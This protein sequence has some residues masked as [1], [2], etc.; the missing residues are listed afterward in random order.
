MTNTTFH[1]YAPFIQQYIYRKGWTDLREVQVD[2]CNAI[3]DTDDHVIIA[4]GTASGKTEAAFFPILTLL[5]QNPSAS[6]GILYIG[7]L[8]ALIN[9]QFQRLEELL[10]DSDIPVWPWHGDVSQSVKTRIRRKKQG[11]VQITPESLESLLMRSPKDAASLFSDLRFVVVDEIHA[12]MGQDRGLQLLC[13]L[14]RLEKF[15]GCSPRRIGLSA[16]LNDYRPAI[17]FLSAGTSRGTVAVGIS[18]HT[19]KIGLC[20]DAFPVPED[21]VQAEQ[22]MMRY[23]NFIYDNCHNRKCLIFT[24]SRNDAETT[25][26]QMKVIA[27][28]RAEPDIFHVHHGSISAQLR[29]EAEHALRD[30]TLPTVAAAT[31]TLELGIDIGDLDSTIQ[32]GAP[33]SCSS[34][35]QRLGRSG[36]R[37]GKSKMMFLS[38]PEETNSLHPDALPWDLLRSLAIIQLYL[39]E[40]WVEPFTMK[41]KPFS[42]LAHQTLSTLMSQGELTPAELARRVLLLPP[43]RNRIEPE[44]YRDLLRNMIAGDYLQRMDNGG[45]IPGMKGERIAGHYTFYSVFPEE[46]TYQVIAAG[47]AIGTLTNCPQP[48]EGF[49]LA[50][51]AWR[52]ITVDDTRKEIHAV[53]SSD[54][55]IPSWSGNSG[56]IHGKIFRRI[57]RLLDETTLWPYLRPNAADLL[58]KARQT[59]ADLGLN[60]KDLLAV[61][62]HSF[63]LFPWC[64]TRQLR[65]L[66]KL[67]TIGLREKLRIIQVNNCEYYLDIRTDLSEAE[68]ISRLRNLQIADISPDLVL[69]P[70]RAPRTD[71]YDYMVPD[72]LLRKAYLHNQMDIPGAL[73]VLK[74]L[75]YT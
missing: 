25:I 12:L 10:T 40:Q 41:E 51:R 44:E 31:L 45:L 6:V 28:K 72:A 21:P 54:S 56:D 49:L 60:R 33:W 53:P 43:F 8:K 23:H 52:V 16:T 32:T 63:L 20:V 7:P 26:S 70:N 66:E 22:T 1:R 61:D 59:A 38:L 69:P 71:K 42:L 48:G 55:K 73:A 75:R 68:F 5:E 57:S 9:D 74:S 14:S 2:A 3:L 50:G 67:L 65:T 64:G 29:Q 18:G 11:V 37:T 39:E 36:R 30:S 58:T 17:D 27:A 46:E 13:L 4:S 47:A 15:T 24:N 19:R 62:K 35:V 34:F